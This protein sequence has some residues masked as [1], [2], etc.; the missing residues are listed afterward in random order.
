MG[1]FAKCIAPLSELYY[2]ADKCGAGA[3]S[4]SGNANEFVAYR[5][6]HGMIDDKDFILNTSCAIS[7]LTAQQM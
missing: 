2:Q 1:D 6:L 7:H 3:L 5:M 4:W